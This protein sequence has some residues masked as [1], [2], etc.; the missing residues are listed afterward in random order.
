MDAQGTSGGTSAAGTGTGRGGTGGGGGPRYRRV[1]VLPV[2]GE[3][4]RDHAGELRAALAAALER[5]PEGADLVVDLGRS[6]FC[7]SAG[8]GVLLEA[9]RRGAESGHAVR[10]ARPSHQQLRLLELTD[11]RSLFPLDGALP[12]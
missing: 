11:T 6:S 1:C 2:R 3:M 12:G 9:R 8:L 10:L 4:D 5:T 7:D